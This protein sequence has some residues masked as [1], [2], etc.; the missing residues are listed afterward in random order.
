MMHK[1][2]YREMDGANDDAILHALAAEVK[3]AAERLW[4]AGWTLEF[5]YVL[6]QEAADLAGA[7]WPGW[8]KVDRVREALN[9]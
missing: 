3:Q 2:W 1:S 6:A 5:A 8:T 4:W 7:G 9:A